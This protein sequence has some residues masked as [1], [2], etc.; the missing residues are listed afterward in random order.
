MKD[1]KLL[2]T[3]YKRLSGTYDMSL[4]RYVADVTVLGEPH[5]GNL[6]DYLVSMGVAKYWDGKGPHPWS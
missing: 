1:H 2:I 5:I 6:A 4:T 3:T